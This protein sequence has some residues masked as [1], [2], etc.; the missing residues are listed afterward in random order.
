MVD[1]AGAAASLAAEARTGLRPN[2]ILMNRPRALSPHATSGTWTGYRVDTKE[3]SL[4]KLTS[5]TKRLL[6][7]DQSVCAQMRSVMDCPA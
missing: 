1:G 6:L 2:A 3:T 4:T 5:S 7:R